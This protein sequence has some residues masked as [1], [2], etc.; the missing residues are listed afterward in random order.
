VRSR[1]YYK[2]TR[3]GPVALAVKL[4]DIHDNL[5]PWRTAQLDPATRARLE[6]KYARARRILAEEV[7]AA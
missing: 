2:A 3:R 4:A 6:S 7:D 1:A 5:L